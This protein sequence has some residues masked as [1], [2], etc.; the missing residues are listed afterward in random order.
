[1]VKERY[2]INEAAKE[3]H[4][5]SHV[6]RYWEEEL[7]LPIKRNEQGHRIYTQEDIDRFIAIKDLKDQG[8]QL[9]AVKTILDQIHSDNGGDEDMRAGNPFAQKQLT[10]I[11]KLGEAK[12]AAIKNS[13]DAKWNERFGRKHEAIAGTSNTEEKNKYSN[14]GGRTDMKNMIEIK[15]IRSLDAMEG[16]SR[17]DY[18]QNDR[19]PEAGQ[20]Q[21]LRLQYLFQKL[22]KDAVAANNKEMADQLVAR[23]TENVKGDLCKELDYQFRLM[24]ERDEE[25]VNTRHE[26]EDKR[27]EE[28]YK[29]IDELLRQYS[30]KNGRFKDKNKEKNKEKQ[31]EKTIEFPNAKEKKEPKAKKEF[32]FFKKAVEA[33]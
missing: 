12:M 25:R 3:V 30:G 13:E 17:P 33:K 14:E 26:L 4:V 24:E 31:K 27:N 15:E 28:Y 23:I 2:L 29:R 20:A 21:T 6:L 18:S 1:M 32:H 8:L 16:P 9:K 19:L 5:E 10:K 7:G 11:T 22:I